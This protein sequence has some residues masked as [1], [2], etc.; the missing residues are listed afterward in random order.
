MRLPS[1]WPIS[2]KLSIWTLLKRKEV[3]IFF[4]AL[5]YFVSVAAAADEASVQ[6]RVLAANPSTGSPLVVAAG[7][8]VVRLGDRAALVVLDADNCALVIGTY[9]DGRAVIESG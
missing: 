8:P 5:V 6:G 7:I 2:Q 3:V 1:D 9:G 4:T